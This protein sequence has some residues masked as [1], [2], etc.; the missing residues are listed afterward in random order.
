[1]KLKLDGK[2]QLGTIHVGLSFSCILIG[3]DDNIEK[4]L[5]LKLELDSILDL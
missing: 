3:N 1:M 5:P 2:K 4:V